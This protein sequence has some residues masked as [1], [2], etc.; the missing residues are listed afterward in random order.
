MKTERKRL[1]PGLALVAGFVLA[2]VVPARSQH[3]QAAGGGFSLYARSLIG[4]EG[5][6][7]LR[8]SAHVP[9]GTLIFLKKGDEFEAEYQLFIKVLDARGEQLIDSAVTKKSVIVSDYKD[10]RS[11]KQ[12][13]T[14]SQHFRLPPGAYVVR[15]M[16]QVKN[17]HRSFVKQAAVVI[18]DVVETG[19]GL[20][21]P[22]MFASA[23]D[24]ARVA[25]TLWPVEE[26]DQQYVEQVEAPVFSAYDQ[27]PAFQFDVHVDKT[28]K[29]TSCRL[30][31]EVLDE[32]DHQILYGRGIVELQ[33]SE[34][35]FV[36]S[37]NVDD[38][39][40]GRYQLNVK[41]ALAGTDQA[42]VTSLQFGLAF[43]RT[44]LT[45]H[46]DETLQIMSYIAT[47]AELAPLRQAPESERGKAW[48]DFWKQRDPDPTTPENEALEEH[49][50]RVRYATENFATSEPG[51]RTDRGKVYIRHG[52]P[53]EI[54]IR[55]DPYIQGD[56]L[57]W[58][59]FDEDLTFT[60][61]DRFGL[62]EYR[63]TNAENN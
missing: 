17:T 32:K 51:W 22:R 20:T 33:G 47:A 4:E 36:L 2:T 48:A 56:Y 11:I 40:P 6:P 58:R 35:Q 52:G 62:G 26:L 37:F 25:K 59:Y 10:T 21:K 13:S 27:Q 42:A 45:K 49:W 61:F 34:R 38:W 9:Y 60:F 7:T 18:T 54:E 3:P 1:I 16:L 50:R 24:T 43:S 41:G 28:G 12:S 55:S 29:P 5:E 46:F 19:I 23:I 30:M 14:L 8:V 15:A 57:I 53:D 44:L 31:Y 39:N 63:L